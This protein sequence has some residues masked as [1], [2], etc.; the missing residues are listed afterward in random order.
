MC[1]DLLGA[2][3]TLT[4]VL[5]LQE[6]QKRKLMAPLNWGM[7]FIRNCIQRCGCRRASRPPGARTANSPESALFTT[8]FGRGGGGGGSGK[9]KKGTSKGK[10][11]LVTVTPSCT[12]DISDSKC[13]LLKV[14][15]SSNQMG[16]CPLPARRHCILTGGGGVGGYSFHRCRLIFI[17]WFC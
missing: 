17:L 7:L 11:A 5:R 8:S 9:T 3:K 10:T 4:N 6:K 13:S 2:G 16:P 15:I 14:T 12:I 1:Q